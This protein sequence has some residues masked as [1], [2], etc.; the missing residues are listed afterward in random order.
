MDA[1]LI[2]NFIEEAENN[3]PVI[4]GGILLCAQ[5][6]DFHAD[7]ISSLDKAHSIRSSA[8]VA[9]LDDIAKIAGRL[10]TA[11]N[12]AASKKKPLTGEQSRFL[13][14]QV[15]QI[16]ALLIKLYFEAGTFSL[17]LDDFVDE[18]FANLQASENLSAAPAPQTA[19]EEDEE[20]AAEE[21]FE[22]DDEMRE[23]FAL[24][25]EDLL[26]N[27]SEHLEKLGKTPNSREA[28]LEI[29]R[30]AHTLK[31]S[32]GIVGLKTLSQ[33]AHRVEDLLDHLAENEIEGDVRIFEILSDSTDCLNALAAN[34]ISE[35]LHK[36]LDQLEAD[37][38]RMMHS[39]RSGSV[40]DPGGENKPDKT[41]ILA[42]EEA[43]ADQPQNPAGQNRSVIRVSI[44][45]LDELVGLVSEMVVSRSV[46]ERRLADFGQQIEELRNNTTRLQRSASRLEIEFDAE[47]LVKAPANDP[48]NAF[49]SRAG[50]FEQA[51]EFDLL[52]LDRYTDFHHTTRELAE[53]GSDASAIGA[54]M[55][56]LRRSLEAVFD[57][58][59]R[60]VEDLQ[61]KL[62]R[63]RMVSF[64]SLNNR[65]LRTLR[66]TAEQEH[67]QV[68]M[69]I[70]GEKLE[71]DT[72]LLDAL[73]EPLLHLLRNAVAHGIE[74]PAARRLL[75]KPE[76]GRVTL[77]VHSEGMHIVASVSD[78]GRGLSASALKEKAVRQGI[79]APDVA[80]LMSESQAFELIF[81]PG[82]ST[83]GEVN[84][85]SGRG[86]G[87]NIVKT[88]VERQKGSISIASE[89]QKG[90]TFTIR[91]PMSLAI[92][93]ALLVR[94]GGQTFAFPLRVVKKIV[95]IDAA[96]IGDKES[97][98]IDNE[99]Y[100]F[101]RINDLLELPAPPKSETVL[102][103]LL[104]A[105][106]E[107]HAVAVEEILKTEEIVVKPL[108]D[109]L[110]GA[111]E[112]VG[113]AILGDGDVV[114]VLDLTELLKTTRKPSAD[115]LKKTTSASEEKGG[116]GEPP[117]ISVLIV[118]DSPSVRHINSKLIKNN[119][120]QAIAARDG[121]E[122][123]EL[124]RS[125]E[126][127][128]NVIL[129]DVEMPRMDGYELLASIRRTET[130][131]DIPVVMITS[132]ASEKHRRKAVDL[133]VT[134]YLTKPYE[135]A[136]LIGIIRGLSASK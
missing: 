82:I 119:G 64:D 91:L 34:D 2:Q 61:D 26:G 108:D 95:E 113:A 128:P 39:F 76:T 110:T 89:A 14:D 27:I 52:E 49:S 46:F 3:L 115:L 32:A 90:T 51:A 5:D 130:L 74:P 58:H 132:R 86:V 57:Q 133:G 118:D 136:Q 54:E 44:E 19:V 35:Q 21:E 92:S 102:T 99:R 60:L 6:G 37:F 103:L 55:E 11:L 20:T 24:E 70:E 122:A 28:L 117:R 135:E 62:L 105:S 36:K 67:K 47:T 127:P 109:F 134:D 42:R 77:R 1:E 112:N 63:L 111:G 116:S 50:S 96:G 84:Y 12:A 97:V 120:M 43:S 107:L 22:I 125:S 7:L 56:N 69:V 30:S 41:E 81:I 45:K 121:I 75:G 10:E 88:A 31:G 114:P 68:E 98:E 72:Q 94:A 65:L 126:T 9:G 16:E 123:L 87:M 131:R 104:D 18:S 25:A 73:V 101:S 59:R 29:R 93:R 17:E 71:I 78:D 23:V 13:L 15:A 8:F 33:L 38:D 129:T 66:V 100:R 83:A 40:M 80:E 85:V 48:P 79:I 106:S 53:T 4:R 124:L